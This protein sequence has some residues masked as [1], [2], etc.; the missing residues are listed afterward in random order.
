MGKANGKMMACKQCGKEV[1]IYKARQNKY[2]FC[3]RKCHAKNILCNPEVRKK[4][5]YISGENNPKWKGGTIRKDGYK[6]TIIKGKREY[7]HRFIMEE[8]L[9][10]KLIGEE[11]IHHINGNRSNNRIENLKLYSNKAEHSLCE[12]HK[13]NKKYND[14][15]FKICIGCKEKFYR[16][17]KKF[18]FKKANYCSHKCYLRHINHWPFCGKNNF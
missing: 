4:R 7:E 11:N 6:L 14:N 9:G 3:S 17:Q 16:W 18:K 12:N 13:P 15:D 10:R 5:K 8:Y 2:K 1:Y